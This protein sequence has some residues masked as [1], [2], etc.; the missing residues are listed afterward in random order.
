MPFFPQHVRAR[1]RRVAAEID[2]DRRREP[3]Q[4]VAV[5]LADEE[6]GLGEIHLPRHVLHPHR[7]GGRGEDADGGGIARKGAIREG[8]YLSNAERHASNLLAR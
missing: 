4:V 8:V 7:L 5:R 1:E 6:R 2:L 3:A